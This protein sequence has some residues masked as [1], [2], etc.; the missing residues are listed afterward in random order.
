M[1]VIFIISRHRFK[2]VCKAVQIYRLG[3]S[4]WLMMI[5]FDI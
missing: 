2:K 4:R 3:R 1:I 5:L